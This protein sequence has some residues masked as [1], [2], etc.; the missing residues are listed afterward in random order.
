MPRLDCSIHASDPVISSSV[1]AIAN[2]TA[3]V[4]DPTLDPEQIQEALLFI[5]EFCIAL[6]SALVAHL[7]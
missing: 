3:R 7:E 6:C 5:G 4:V 2:Y 1:A